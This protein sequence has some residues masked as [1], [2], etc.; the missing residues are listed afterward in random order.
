MEVE[1]GPLMLS[2]RRTS[3]GSKSR[4]IWCQFEESIFSFKPVWLIAHAKTSAM[5]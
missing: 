1:L 4:L 5:L 2:V 3:V